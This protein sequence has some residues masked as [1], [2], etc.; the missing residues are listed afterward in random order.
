[1]SVLRWAESE[2][3][4]DQLPK[5]VGRLQPTLY[6]VRRRGNLPNASTCHKAAR[7]VATTTKNLIVER[8]CGSES[9][10]ELSAAEKSVG[11]LVAFRGDDI[12]VFAHVIK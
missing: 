6:A 1:M 9:L 12:L 3:P 8:V 10:A 11:V 5:A 4:P 2:H 7:I